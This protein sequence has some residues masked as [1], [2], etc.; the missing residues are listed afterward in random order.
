ML[1]IMNGCV[2]GI[3]LMARGGTLVVLGVL[4]SLGVILGPSDSQAAIATTTQNWPA[5]P[6]YSAAAYP[7]AAITYNA[8][9]GNNRLL[10]VGISSSTTAVAQAQPTV[11]YGG[12]AMTPAVGYS[13][14]ATQQH[15]YLFYL[16]LG[17]SATADAGKT[18]AVTIS[19]GTSKHCIVNAAVYT[20]VDQATPVA[21]SVRS[22]NNTTTGTAVGPFTLAVNSGEMGVSVLNTVQPGTTNLNASTITL[23]ATGHL[24][25]QVST[26]ASAR[27]KGGGRY[28]PP[29]PPPSTPIRLRRPSIRHQPLH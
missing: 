2:R 17:S 28:G 10:V 4:V 1:N 16:P 8:V 14:T 5:T 9:A 20:G 3:R 26:A 23:G 18:I 29:L 24:W 12:T 6:I 11:S 19:G 13:A 7:S 21:A 22:S 25:T 15:S 27:M